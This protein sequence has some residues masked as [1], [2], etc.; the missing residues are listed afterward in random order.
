MTVLEYPVIGLKYFNVYGPGEE[1][2]NHMTSV[3]G[4]K[5][6]QVFIYNIN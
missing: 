6:N 5:I 1:H 2:K 4:Q 3:I